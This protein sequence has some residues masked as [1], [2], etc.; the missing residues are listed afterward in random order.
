M[1]FTALFFGFDGRIGRLTYLGASFLLTLV[2]VAANAAFLGLMARSEGA[3]ALVL[4]TGFAAFFAAHG[5]VAGALMA[6]R[7]HDLDMSG[8]HAAWIL[9]AAVMTGAS[10]AL[11]PALAV[12]FG[13]VTLVAGA[14]LIVVPGT[15]GPNRFGSRAA[16]TDEPALA[17]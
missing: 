5:C 15:R 13:L 10:A 17:H 11:A 2:A 9:A 8:A 6:K 16:G 7:L 4:W 1:S 3:G 14:V 12:I